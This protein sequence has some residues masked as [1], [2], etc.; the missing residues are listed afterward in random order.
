MHGRAEALAWLHKNAKSQLENGQAL[1]FD[2]GDALIGSNTVWK[3]YE[4]NLERMGSVFCTS[5]AMGNREFNYQRRILDMRAAQ[6]SFPLLCSNLSDIREDGRLAN[7]QFIDKLT[8][9]PQLDCEKIQY[10]QTKEWLEL[11]SRRWIPALA[12]SN[13]GWSAKRSLLLLAAVPVQYP[14][15]AI[16]EKLFNFRF[17]EAEIVLP[18][19]VKRCLKL[20][21]KPL[22]IIVLS[23]LGLNK[24]KVLASALPSGSWILGGHSHT[25]LNEPLKI[26]G[27]FITQ[28]GAFTNYIGQLDYNIEHPE[29]STYQLISLH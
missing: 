3:N 8:S 1:Y 20:L 9:V 18:L 12:L 5:M 15:E 26:D 22:N 27:T 7:Q 14:H 17:F 23:H 6:R 2:S 10:R 24:D 19:L 11:A 25:V 28:T 21:D 13:N 16:W 29:L 4:P